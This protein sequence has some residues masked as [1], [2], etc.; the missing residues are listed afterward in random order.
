MKTPLWTLLLLLCLCASGHCDCQRDCLSCG[1]FLPQNHGFNA[2][3][4]LVECEDNMSPGLTW[5]LCRQ[6]ARQ[7][8]LPSQPAGGDVLKRG[9]EEEARIALPVD[10]ADGGLLYSEAL[11]R[12]RHAAQA[13]IADHPA[14][15]RQTTSLS[16][17]SHAQQL[18][19]RE[20]E[21]VED[22]EEEEEEEEGG[23][24]AKHEEPAVSLSKRFGGFLKGRYGYR[25]LMDPG[26]PL[27][28]RYGGFIGI[29]KSARKWNNQKRVSEFL[30]QYLGMTRH[31]RKFHS[32]SADFTR[33]NEV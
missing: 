30:K 14:G 5:E 19:S 26:R 7:L 3:V 29:R 6:A 20:E 33:Q 21:R 16:T 2:L 9:E 17:T 13:L 1:T 28:K 23:A 31:S 27:H 15:A 32:L 11:Q 8:Q 4:C 24:G 18:G 25:K 10:L 22:E 12:F